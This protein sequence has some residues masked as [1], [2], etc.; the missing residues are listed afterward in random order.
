MKSGRYSRRGE[1]RA[2]SFNFRLVR[3]EVMMF[4]ESPEY[5]LLPSVPQSQME[6]LHTRLLINPLYYGGFWDALR[7]DPMFGLIGGPSIE[8]LQGFADAAFSGTPPTLIPSIPLRDEA[9][10]VY[11]IEFI[12]Y[13]SPAEFS[14]QDSIEQFLTATNAWT[15]WSMLQLA[16]VLQVNRWSSFH[17]HGGRPRK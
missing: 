5:A 12:H 3:R 2:S 7:D 14:A 17:Q 15:V 1:R 10:T 9:S 11:G 13:W 8:I 16:L 6:C 4:P